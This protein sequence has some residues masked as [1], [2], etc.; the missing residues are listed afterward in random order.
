MLF[1]LGNDAFIPLWNDTVF[2]LRDNMEVPLLLSAKKDRSRYFDSAVNI[3]FRTFNMRSH[4]GVGK[5]GL[6]G[7]DDVGVKYDALVFCQPTTYRGL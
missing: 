4:G 6:Y 2:P 5:H 1:P 7:R 3:R